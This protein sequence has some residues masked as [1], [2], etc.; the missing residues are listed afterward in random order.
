VNDALLTGHSCESL[1]DVGD[2]CLLLPEAA[3][4]FSALANDARVAGFELQMAS[5]HRSFDRQL[6]IF[7]GKLAGERPVLDEHDRVI[8]L[9]ALTLDE[10][11][12]AIL[13]FSALPGGSRHHWGTDLDVYDAAAVGDDYRLQ[14]SQA[15]V[16][17][18]GVFDALHCWLD[19]RF[20][21]GAG[22]GFYRPYDRDRG[23]VAPERW[24]LSYAP[25]ACQFEARVDAAMIARCWRR[26]EAHGLLLREE[27]EARLPDLVQRYL[28]NVAPPPA[29]R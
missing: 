10:R 27:L 20:S 4:A 24:H 18:G 9:A 28:R 12:A 17:P 2:G 22:R 3:S 8:D 23:G 11:F 14:L 19:E 5:A 15:E 7:N 25:L 21:G 1:V 29:M 16:A 26:P 6:T 13:R